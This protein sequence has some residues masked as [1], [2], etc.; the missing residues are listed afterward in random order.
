MA[1]PG[2]QPRRVCTF[3]CSCVCAR[4]RGANAFVGCVSRS[5]GDF[6][7]AVL[8]FQTCCFFFRLAVLVLAGLLFLLFFVYSI[9]GMNFFYNIKS[10]EWINDHAHFRDFGTAF[11][12]VF[13]ATTGENWNGLMHDC[14]TAKCSVRSRHLAA[15]LR[16]TIYRNFGYSTVKPPAKTLKAT[17]RAAVEFL[18]ATVPLIALCCDVLMVGCAVLC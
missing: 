2:C 3:T 18:Y 12:T 14:V 8:F 15:R 5:D 4:T 10:Q 7:P 6:R 11:M 1:T 17:L 16:H 9:L 13:R